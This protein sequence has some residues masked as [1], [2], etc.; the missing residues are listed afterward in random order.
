MAVYP[1][2]GPPDAEQLVREAVA[3]VHAATGLD[4]VVSG[5][6]GDHAPN[7]NFEAAPVHPDDP[8]RVSWQDGDAIAELSD[9]VAGL[10]GNR[11]MTNPNGSRRL[12]PP[13]RSLGTTTRS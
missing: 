7:W 4:I 13:S 2:G 11:T 1:A 10:G 12:V 8:I 5:A 3:Q 6:F 9:H